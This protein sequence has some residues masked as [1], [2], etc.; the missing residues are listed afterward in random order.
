MRLFQY[1]GYLL[2]KYQGMN[3]AHFF[4]QT[5][6]P[7]GFNVHTNYNCFSGPY[8][9]NVGWPLR[10]PQCEFDRQTLVVCH[11]QDFVTIKNGQCVELQQVEQ[12][13]GQHANQVL[14]TYWTSDLHL[15]YNGP[16]NL[17]K[18]SNHNYDIANTLA[19]NFDQWR[20]VLDQPRTHSWQ[21]LNGRICMHRQR[22]VDILQTWTGGWLSLGNYLPLPGWSYQNYF[23][24]ENYNNFL[25]LAYVYGST[26]VNIVTETEYD[27]PIGIVTEKTLLAIAAQQVPVVIGHQGI[28]QHCR[29][30]GF[31][32][33]DDIVNNSYDLLPNDKRVEQ[34]LLL[35][36][37]LILG[38]KDL[39]P[40]RARLKANREYLLWQFPRLMEAQWLKDVKQLAS[41]L[42]S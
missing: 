40:Y 30:L 42:L 1:I 20:S 36:R 2:G 5:L 25:N 41:K 12:H 11:F 4:N 21:C 15:M 22:A 6:G 23:G 34:A 31:D 27:P 38:R 19:E 28:V 33:F 10:L 8:Q 14:V 9:H 29:D 35:N 3:F 37:D 16:V 17:I 26:P 7:V 24:C 18:F 32:M 39:S 13:Y